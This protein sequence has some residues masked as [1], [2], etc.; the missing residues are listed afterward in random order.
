M[1]QQ[2]YDVTQLNIMEMLC[3][4]T[5]ISLHNCA[6]A[7]LAHQPKCLSALVQYYYLVTWSPLKPKKSTRLLVQSTCTEHMYRSKLRVIHLG[8]LRLPVSCADN[9]SCPVCNVSHSGSHNRWLHLQ[10]NLMPIWHGG[11]TNDGRACE[12][13]APEHANLIS[14]TAVMTAMSSG[15]DDRGSRCSSHRCTSCPVAERRLRCPAIN[16]NHK[17][18]SPRPPGPL[19]IEVV[20]TVHIAR[21]RV[22]LREGACAALR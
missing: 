13:S 16:S 3:F 11:D 10:S 7:I 19:T 22:L 17:R 18:G 14:V 6:L 8:C 1:L 20:D 21:P 5:F 9:R 12:A 2:T 15:H 4:I